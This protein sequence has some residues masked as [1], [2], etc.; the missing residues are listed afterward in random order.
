MSSGTNIQDSRSNEI[1]DSGSISVIVPVVPPCCPKCS[2]ESL[3]DK[4]ERQRMRERKETRTIIQQFIS[5]M[6]Y[7]RSYGSI[8]FWIICLFVMFSLPISEFVV[9]SLDEKVCNRPKPITLD[10]YILVDAVV[11]SVHLVVYILLCWMK[12]KELADVISQRLCIFWIIWITLGSV[13]LFGYNISYETCQDTHL[14]RMTLASLILRFMIS[15]SIFS[16]I[17]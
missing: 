14:Y 11:H 9:H 3:Y 2:P 13:S 8:F 4:E 5:D 15:T 17:F 7:F 16:T 12:M 6:L 1:L 10:V